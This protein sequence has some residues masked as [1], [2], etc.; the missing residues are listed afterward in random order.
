MRFRLRCHECRKTII[1]G[2]SKTVCGYVDAIHMAAFGGRHWS[3]I[4]RQPKRARRR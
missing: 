4:W 1:K 2:A 3:T